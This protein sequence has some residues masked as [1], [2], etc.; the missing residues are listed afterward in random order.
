MRALPVNMAV[1][2]SRIGKRIFGMF[3][4]CSFL[5]ILI[6]AGLS[7]S[8]V[9]DQLKDQTAARLRQTTKSVGMSIYERL[10]FLEAEMRLL[11]HTHQQETPDDHAAIDLSSP[12]QI[13]PRFRSI[14]FAGPDGRLIPLQNRMAQVPVMSTGDKEHLQTGRSIFKTIPQ[15]SGPARI[16]LI[17]STIFGRHGAGILIGEVNTAYLWGIGQQYNLPAFNEL[18]VFDHSGQVLISSIPHADDVIRQAMAP[19]R[20][21]DS[22]QFIWQVEDRDYL[23]S[24]WNLFLKSHFV[25]DNWTIVL[26]QDRDDALAVIRS[27]KF[28]FPMVLLVGFWLILLISI[29]LIR[30]SLVP[31]EKLQDATRRIHDGDFSQNVSVHSNDEFEDLAASFNLMRERLSRTFGEL[32]VMAEMGHFV[33]T[34][35]AVI[36][37]VMT[38]LRIMAAKLHFGWGMFMI[39]GDV[40]DGDPFMAGF[41]LPREMHQCPETVGSIKHGSP[42]DELMAYALRHRDLIHTK[43]AAEL[44]SILPPA[45]TAFLDRRGCQSLI[46][47][48]VVFE[49]HLLGTLAVGND[50][51]SPPLTDSDKDLLVGIAAQIAVAINNIV[52]F[53]QL[54]ESE[55]RFREAFDHAATGILLVSTDFHIRASNR[56]LQQLLGYAETELIDQYLDDLSIPEDRA[57]GLESRKLMLTGQQTFAQYAKRYRHKEGHAVWVR[58]N[59]SL[60]RDTR[61]NPVQFIFHV[62]DL[63]AEKAAE[64]DKHRLESQLRQAQK[65]EAI[66]T[67]AGGIAHD[68]NNILSA[69]GGY[70]E[71]AMMQLPEASKIHADLANVRKATD[72]AT[73]LVRQ[74]LAFSRQSEHE[75]IPI[76]ISSIVKEALQLLRASLPA[77]IEIR[78]AIDAAP[79]F[80]M[81]DPTQVH[82][83]VMNLC[84]NALHAM[85][86]AGG[87]LDVRLVQVF[88]GPEEARARHHIQTGSYLKL[89]VADTGFGMD[90]WTRERIF[91]PYFTTKEKGKGTGLGLAVVHGIVE[92]HHGTIEVASEPGKGTTFDVYFPVAEKQQH[93]RA[94]SVEEIPPGTERV[95]FIDDEPMLV[96]LG[97]SMLAKQGYRVVGMTDPLEALE[98]FRRTPDQFDLVITDLTMPGI[99]GDRLAEKLCAIRPGL[100]ILLCSGYVQ[101]VEHPCLSGCIHKPVNLRDLHRAVRKVLEE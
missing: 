10:V 75:K 79:A 4:C 28:D 43:D 15:E 17:F 13:V 65:M 26:S 68:F 34:R 63:T 59:S 54:E 9:K 81:A 16:L 45:C 44:A 46:C 67:L 19:S 61:D 91:E 32:S 62:R 42:L 83:I 20:A 96:E 36:D 74:I 77:T 47:A 33:T 40:L 23:A 73:D 53:Q 48:P 2:K 85:Q 55:T 100:P 38:A 29:R 52:S 90:A 99:T 21:A 1:F 24:S 92:S 18:T 30:K 84:T 72:R 12:E 80:V 8:H 25:A 70:T 69:V 49:N 88:L 93:R 64:S 86:D 95:L 89:T 58:I 56:Y 35:P 50:G 5:P 76:Q 101:N 78:K 98:A 41:G 14:A 57:I 51:G 22:Q 37:L 31:L 60:M 94:A 97:K 39:Q 66:G 82:Q 27:F 3:V 7:Y 11:A 87:T 6:L 71:L